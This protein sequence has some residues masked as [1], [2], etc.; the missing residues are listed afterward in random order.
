MLSI[1]RATGELHWSDDPLDEGD[2][3]RGEIVLR[4][5]VLVRPAFCPVLSRHERVDLARRVL[6]WFVQKDE[7]ASQTAG[8]VGQGTLSVTLRLEGPNAEIGLR[9]DGLGLPDERRANDPVRVGVSVS[10]ARS[11][12]A[13]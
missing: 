6:G 11:G 12:P 9:R 5:Q 7:E 8:E 13:C 1:V 2:F 4:V 3:T 10:G